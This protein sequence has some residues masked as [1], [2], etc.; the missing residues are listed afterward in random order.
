MH[1]AKNNYITRIYVLAPLLRPPS[2]RFSSQSTP[3][4]T[5]RFDSGAKFEHRIRRAVKSRSSDCHDRERCVRTIIIDGQPLG[6]VL[7]STTTRSSGLPTTYRADVKYPR[8]RTEKDRQRWVDRKR[9]K[10]ALFARST[11]S[12]PPH[13]ST[14]SSLAN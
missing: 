2:P 9:E 10:E 5:Q 14:R 11:P 12:D 7:I 4:L 1:K 13:P 3:L 8:N 6:C